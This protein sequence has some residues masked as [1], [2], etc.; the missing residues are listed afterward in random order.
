MST[1]RCRFP[2]GSPP[3]VV[4]EDLPVFDLVGVAAAEGWD[5]TELMFFVFE[6]GVEDGVSFCREYSEMKSRSQQE[7]RQMV[8]SEPTKEAMV[9]FLFRGTGGLGV[10]EV[11]GG[12][13]LEAWFSGLEGRGP[14]AC[15]DGY[16]T[17]LGGE[18]S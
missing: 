2:P 4:D 6:Y 1:M 10:Q 8:C 12:W 13:T 18:S 7:V 9:Q 3:L 14:G 16:F 11:Q 5:Q 17:T 15:T